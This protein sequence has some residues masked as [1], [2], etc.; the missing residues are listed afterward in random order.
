MS[1]WYQQSINKNHLGVALDAP[2]VGN[3]VVDLHGLG[4]LAFGPLQPLL[5]GVDIDVGATGGGGA[6]PLLGLL[7]G[8]GAGGGGAEEVGH[9]RLRDVEMGG[10]ILNTHCRGNQIVS[11]SE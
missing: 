7:A 3:L 11:V 8:G 9:L 10:S 2:V 5:D 6:G 4:L 1:I